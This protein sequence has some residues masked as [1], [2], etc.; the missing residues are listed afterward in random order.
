MRADGAVSTVL[1]PTAG[2]SISRDGHTAIVQAGTARDANG[3]VAAADR[4][5][6]KLAALTSAG[7]RVSLTGAR[8]A[9]V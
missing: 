5:K 3:M 7:V 2:V 1:A 8:G 4:L 9:V 6:G